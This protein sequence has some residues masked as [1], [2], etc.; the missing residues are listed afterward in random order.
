MKLKGN[1]VHLTE[2]REKL[3]PFYAYDVDSRIEKLLFDIWKTKHGFHIL[4]S[5]ELTLVDCLRISE[6]ISTETN[7]VTNPAPELVF[8]GCGPNHVE[9]EN[10]GKKVIYTTLG[11]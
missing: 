7:Q 8:C 6:K 2:G 5:K 3:A 11:D 9:L 10:I 1:V 4:S